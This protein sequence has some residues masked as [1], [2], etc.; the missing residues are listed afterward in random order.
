MNCPPVPAR[1]TRSVLSW[2]LVLFVALGSTASAQETGAK[3]DE[4]T[5]KVAEPA[6]PARKAKRPDPL[7]LPFPQDFKTIRD[8]GVWSIAAQSACQDRMAAARQRGDRAR[9]AQL[10]S[11]LDKV[12]QH[13]ARM[14]RKLQR[15][16][17]T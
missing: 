8:L 9:V 12:R 16:V 7:A 3:S 2:A 15:R 11:R 14:L 1:L 4:P 6:S 13:A 10:V 5:K 17:T